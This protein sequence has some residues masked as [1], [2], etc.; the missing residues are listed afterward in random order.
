MNT[1]TVHLGCPCASA[2]GWSVQVNT[3]SPDAAIAAAVASTSVCPRCGQLTAEC[4]GVM[5]TEP[6]NELAGKY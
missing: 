5:R 3:D 4:E 2:R 1:Y 6:A